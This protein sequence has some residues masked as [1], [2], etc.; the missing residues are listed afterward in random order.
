MNLLV[1]CL[2]LFLYLHVH[3]HNKTCNDL[4][5]YEIELPSKDKL[6]EVCD[7]RQPVVFDNSND[8]M[9][10]SCNRKSIE[11]TYGAF[12]VKIRNLTDTIG[13]D[14]EMY[15]PISFTSAMAASNADNDKKYLIEAGDDFLE[16]TAM[17]KLFK[18][19]DSFI[20]PHMV[21][22]CMYDILCG[23]DGLRTPFRYEMNYRNYF[24]V[25]EGSVKIKL[26]PPKSS[27]YLHKHSDYENF[28]FRSPIN[29]W[30]VQSNY[31]QDFDKIKCLEVVV[32]KGFMIHLPA[33]WWYSIEFGKETT[34]ASFKYRTYMNTVAI[35]PKLVLNVLQ[36][37]NVKRQI[38][39][40]KNVIKEHNNP[41]IKLI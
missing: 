13:N 4:E 23:C 25:T 26:A 38:A 31:K 28:E 27:K 34:I 33:F 11:E 40:I 12:S 39:S 17:I 10:T 41:E 29:P 6:E 36:S 18:Y 16:E 3:F 32:N 21:S 19:N 2:V 15:I 8:S 37:Q 1:F 9:M 7:L 22:K 35:L 24:M 30:D 14:E 5:L 20:R